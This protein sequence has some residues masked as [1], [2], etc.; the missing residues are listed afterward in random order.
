MK[1]GIKS[2]EFYVTL[3]STIVSLLVMSGYLAADQA[4]E[5]AELIA[6]AIA[7]IVALGSIV[8]YIYSRTALKVKEMEREIKG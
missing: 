2:S 3:G 7:G 4:S 5:T 6:Q 8:S 1:S